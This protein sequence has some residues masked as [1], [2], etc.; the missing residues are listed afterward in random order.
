MGPRQAGDDR[1]AARLN[2]TYPIEDRTVSR[3]HATI[4]VRP[5]GVVV[6]DMV[7]LN[8]TYVNDDVVTGKAHV[9][10]G[11]LV[12]FGSVGLVFRNANGR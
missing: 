6:K 3:V 4:F 2:A 11:D 7:S 1:R 5:D 8:G 9:E 12:S 10:D